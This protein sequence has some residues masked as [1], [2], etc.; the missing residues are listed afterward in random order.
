MLS[1]IRSCAAVFAHAQ[2]PVRAVF[3]YARPGMGC[4]IENDADRRCGRHRRSACA[5]R[6]PAPAG[7]RSAGSRSRRRASLRPRRRGRAPVGDRR[8]SRP[9]CPARRTARRWP[10][11][12]RAGASGSV[13][14]AEDRQDLAGHLR[15]RRLQR[16]GAPGADG[17][18]CALAR[19]RQRRPAP[20]PFGRGRDQ[21][22]LPGHPRDPSRRCYGQPDR[23][24]GPS[25]RTGVPWSG[26]PSADSFP[27][28]RRAPPSWRSSWRCSRPLAAG[29]KKYDPRRR[30][31]RTRTSLRSKGW[32]CGSTSTTTRH[33]PI[34]RPRSPTWPSTACTPC[35]WRPRTSTGRSRSWTSLAWRRSSTRRTSTG[36]TWWRGTCPG[37]STRGSTPSARRPRIPVP[38]GCGQRVRR[39]RVGHRGAGCRRRRRA[40]HAFAGPV[41]SPPD[42][43]G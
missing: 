42:V 5:A 29:N 4:L 36:S 30:C 7:S 38:H 9:G 10:R 13:T 33:G 18:T 6:R 15:R 3:E 27:R 19:H 32:A 43:R 17:H 34:R 25:R 40:D 23:V 12:E 35:T 1:P 31:A 20:E 26:C 16:L 37:S 14:S 24:A 41:G 39:V 8:R 21:R 11:P 28:S 2:R 22:D